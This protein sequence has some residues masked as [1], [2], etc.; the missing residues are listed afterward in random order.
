MVEDDI[1]IKV[2]TR[3]IL[4]QKPE[5]EEKLPGII[6]RTK[7]AFRKT[8]GE[9]IQ[10]EFILIQL[11]QKEGISLSIDQHLQP[12]LQ[13]TD[14]EMYLDARDEIKKYY[15]HVVWKKLERVIDNLCI[16]IDSYDKSVHEK[17]QTQYWLS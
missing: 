2:L 13:R 4:R 9:E 11:T 1:K 8:Y 5:L 14:L 7:A 10:T 3:E 6:T 17:L 15:E 16:E 12:K